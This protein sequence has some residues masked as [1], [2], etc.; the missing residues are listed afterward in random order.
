M[1]S[2]LRERTERIGLELKDIDG[3]D[4][5]KFAF[6]RDSKE[7]GCFA[8]VNED[9]VPLFT[10]QEAEALVT[11]IE[12]VGS[13]EDWYDEGEENDAS[14]EDDGIAMSGTI[15]EWN[16]TFGHVLTDC[17]E[18][19]AF[20]RFLLTSLGFKAP[21]KVGDRM[22]FDA[23]EDIRVMYHIERI[24]LIEPR[25]PD[26]AELRRLRA[27]HEGR[28]DRDA[29]GLILR[30]MEGVIDW[31]DADKGYGFIRSSEGDQ[32]LLHLT[33]LRACGY[34]DAPRPG[35]AVEFEAMQRS[36]GWQAFRL[37]SLEGAVP[38]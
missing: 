19:V 25:E 21:V 20:M 31:Y 36:K 3:L 23:S 13:F 22:H 12:S 7:D 37:L 18:R 24:R 5:P 14:A 6:V 4:P 16:G 9:G 32:V 8:L 38:K 34:R 17:G 27:Q 2:A 29:G 35:A 26:A 10:F 11:E 28:L 30:T 15:V 33:C 1:L